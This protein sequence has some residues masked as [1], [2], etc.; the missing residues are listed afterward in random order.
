MKVRSSQAHNVSPVCQFHQ[1]Y[2]PAIVS[3]VPDDMVRAIADFIEFCYLAR[4]SVH[5][6]DTIKQLEDALARFH[7]HREVFRTFGVCQDFSLPRQHS[8]EHYPCHIRKCGAPNGLCSSI[9]E[10]SI[11]RQSRN[12]TNIQVA[13]KLFI[14]KN[15]YT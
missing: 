15:L 5:T 9:T 6:D 2:L 10:S 7:V 14:R 12:P 13:S 1:V 8:L 3:L 4:R 11:S